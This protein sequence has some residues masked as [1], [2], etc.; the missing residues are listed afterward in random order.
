M[1]SGR[2]RKILTADPAGLYYGYRGYRA[3]RSA[4]AIGSGL[5][6]VG[7]MLSQLGHNST[8]LSLDV[9]NS[10]ALNRLP[11]GLVKTSVELALDKAE[12]LGGVEAGGQCSK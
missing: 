10:I 8:S 1:R 9:V 12:E 6:L 4:A 3:G 7:E 2:I 11:D 5:A